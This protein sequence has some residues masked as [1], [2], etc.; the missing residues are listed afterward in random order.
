MTSLIDAW[1]ECRQDTLDS[2]EIARCIIDRHPKLVDEWVR[3]TVH[4]R[5]TAW[6]SEQE[7]SQRHQ[8]HRSHTFTEAAEE[9]ERTG[10]GEVFLATFAKRAPFVNKQQGELRRADIEIIIGGYT[11]QR[12]SAGLQALVWQKVKKKIGLKR[13]D[14][15]YTEEQFEA[16]FGTTDRKEGTG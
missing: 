5:L 13:V 11:E 3:A 7:R 12:D 15:V 8:R 9:F 16:L 6:V 10:D 14:E 1:L 2:A 4:T